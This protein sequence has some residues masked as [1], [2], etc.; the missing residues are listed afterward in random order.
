MKPIKKTLKQYARLSPDQRIAE[1]KNWIEAELD[2]TRTCLQQL[3]GISPEGDSEVETALGTPLDE[4]PLLISTYEED[5]MANKIV[6]K[7]LAD[8]ITDDDIYVLIDSEWGAE[9]MKDYF[10]KQASGDA[11]YSQAD[12][13]TLHN[14]YHKITNLMELT[15]ILGEEDLYKKVATWLPVLP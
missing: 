3:V 7:R 6:K 5:S 8:S 10:Q 13:D 15:T 4:L 14:C 1:L 9:R 2:N 12:E 11:C